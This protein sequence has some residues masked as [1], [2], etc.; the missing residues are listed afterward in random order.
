MWINTDEACRLTQRTRSA[1]KSW[2]LR[3]IVAARKQGGEWWYDD[4]SLLR[5]KELMEY[6]YVMRKCVP[7]P[8]RGR[9]K[10][11]GMDELW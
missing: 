10:P 2:R 11:V 1:V 5:A 6:N 3:G 8:G 7:G 9:F 4:E